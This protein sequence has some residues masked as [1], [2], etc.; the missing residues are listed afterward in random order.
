MPTPFLV[1]AYSTPGRR[2]RVGWSRRIA[3]GESQRWL[4]ARHG[5]SR[6]GR[7]TSKKDAL[8]RP[9]RG[10]EEGSARR[11]LGRRPPGRCRARRPQESLA[12]GRTSRGSPR[13][14]LQRSLTP[15]FTESSGCHVTD[16]TSDKQGSHRRIDHPVELDVRG[17]GRPADTHSRRTF[18]KPK[19]SPALSIRPGRA[20]GGRGPSTGS[21]PRGE[22]EGRG[23][24]QGSGEGD[25]RNHPSTGRGAAQGTDSTPADAAVS[26]LAVAEDPDRAG[27]AGTAQAAIT[28]RILRQVLL[29]V[30]LGVV[31]GPRRGNLRRGRA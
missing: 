3:P 20:D 11:E 13:R 18:T 25:G 14:E 1:A 19:D 4:V 16:M 26:G 6:S 21:H 22:R 27:D 24:N 28:T 5:T 31:E 8:P 12:A 29:V 7:P 9:H 30:L 2:S 15:G 17:P 10:E 23:P